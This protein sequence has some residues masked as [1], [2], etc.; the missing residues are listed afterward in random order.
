MPPID[1]KACCV[2]ASG[3]T[4]QADTLLTVSPSAH[5]M[6]KLYPDLLCPC[7]VHYC[8]CVVL[9]QNMGHILQ[10][11]S[12][13]ELSCSDFFPACLWPGHTGY[14][15][16]GT[17]RY[18]FCLYPR[19]RVGSSAAWVKGSPGTRWP[20]RGNRLICFGSHAELYY[21]VCGGWE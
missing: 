12:C 6:H 11:L 4:H 8:F 5:P 9:R 21:Y 1:Y 10:F 19:F 17:V 7:W 16:E 15:Q 2:F 3:L 14:L 13:G 18:Q 20:G